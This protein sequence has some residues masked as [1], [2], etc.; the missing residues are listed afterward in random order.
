MGLYVEKFKPILLL[1]DLVEGDDLKNMK[2]QLAQT[3]VTRFP[4]RSGAGEYVKLISVSYGPT[5]IYQQPIATTI[6]PSGFLLLWEGKMTLD[7]KIL[8][9]TIWTVEPI[10]LVALGSIIANQ[11]QMVESG[12]FTEVILEST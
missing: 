8:E 3:V 11:E 6:S 7:L 4:D 9:W 1:L 12:Y 10:M 2:R 5:N